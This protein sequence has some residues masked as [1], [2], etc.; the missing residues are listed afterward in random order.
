MFSEQAV[1]GWG[2]LYSISW[3][4][5]LKVARLM[6]GRK[7]F[8]KSSQTVNSILML[9][10]DENYLSGSY[11]ANLKESGIAAQIA[12]SWQQQMLYCVFTQHGNN[13]T[14]DLLEEIY[15]DLR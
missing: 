1:G 13:F 12:K 6:C 14:H 8:G 9:P 3:L 5:L 11:L 2:P 4:R 10:G 7:H 15:R